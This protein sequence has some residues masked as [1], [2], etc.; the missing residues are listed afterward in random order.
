MPTRMLVVFHPAELCAIAA[1]RLSLTIKMAIYAAMLASTTYAAH[2]CHVHH[3]HP[4]QVHKHFKIK[5]SSPVRK[6][7]GT[8]QKYSSHSHSHTSISTVRLVITILNNTNTTIPYFIY[9]VP[10]YIIF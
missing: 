2:A 10:D 7:I 6:N 1:E 8:S 4:H 9:P 5:S 3:E